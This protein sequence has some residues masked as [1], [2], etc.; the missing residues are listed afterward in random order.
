[1][2][3]CFVWCH[4]GLQMRK[5]ISLTTLFSFVLLFAT[6]I[7]LYVAPH[8]RVAYWAHWQWAN[9]TKTQWGALHTNLGLLFVVA[10][11]WH[12]VLNWN[13]I[14][15]YIVRSRRVMCSSATGWSLL[16]TLVVSVG[17]LVNIPPF[18][19]VMSVSEGFKD[20]A[21]AVYGEPPY[22]HAE[23]SSLMVLVRHTGLDLDTVVE[24]L[25]VAQVVFDS[26]EQSVLEIAQ[27]NDLSPQ[28]LFELIKPVLAAGE[29]L[30]LPQLPPT[31]V[32][33][34]TLSEICTTYGLDCQAVVAALRVTQSDGSSFAT[35]EISLK[36]LAGKQ[37]VNPMTL[38]EKIYQLSQTK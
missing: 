1:M 27:L 30:S 12:L 10:S 7:V 15:G 17:T 16:I 21:S 36:E 31:G 25:K 38:Y 5:I 37:G 33:R 6:S 24:Q 34:L 19:T 13:A 29:T 14:V 22:G 32:G 20:R 18:S 11:V 3:S 35:E 23:L 28:Q 4:K 2:L 26:A 8:G 9:L